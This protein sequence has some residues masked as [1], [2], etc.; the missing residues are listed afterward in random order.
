MKR[1]NSYSL[2][3]ILLEQ[4]KAEN[5]DGIYGFLMTRF[6]YH[7]SRIEGNSLGLEQVIS[8]FQSRTVRSPWEF[9]AE[10]LIEIFNH[11]TCME[12]VL[13]VVE[14]PVSEEMICRLHGILKSSLWGQEDPGQY[15]QRENVVGGRM[16]TPPNQVQ[17]EIQKLLDDYHQSQAKTLKDLLD[18]HVRF[19]RIHP[20]QD[21]NGRVGRLILLKECL[22]NNI[23]PFII[24]DDLKYFYYRGLNE[25]DDEKGYLMDTCLLAQDRFKKVLDSFGIPY[26]D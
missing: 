13:E 16:T 20:F 1:M 25:W 18:F 26:S 10:D 12:Y 7:S 15:K 11:L 6:T 14:E 5:N 22:R 23:T 24:T 3:Q 8:A 21:G 9:K 2:K 17:P 4:R 19:E